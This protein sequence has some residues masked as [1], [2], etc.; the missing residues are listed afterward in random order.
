MIQESAAN[1]KWEPV[2]IMSEFQIIVDRMLNPL[3]Y[4]AEFSPPSLEPTNTIRI[5]GSEYYV[6]ASGLMLLKELEG[7]LNQRFENGKEIGKCCEILRYYQNEINGLILGARAVHTGGLK[8]I[9]AKHLGNNDVPPKLIWLIGSI[10]ICAQTSAAI[11]VMIPEVKTRMGS[12]LSGAQSVLLN[13]FDPV[14]RVCTF[15]PNHDVRTE[16]LPR[17]IKNT[18]STCTTNCM[19]S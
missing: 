13:Q 19:R 3:E 15:E 2:T 14:L 16:T 4:S 5:K 8:S 11:G 17:L 18:R 6:S 9:G 12:K 7:Y 1:D 10:A